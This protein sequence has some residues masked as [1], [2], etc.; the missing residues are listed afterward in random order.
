MGITICAL[1]GEG[2][3]DGVLTGVALNI[4]RYTF[5]LPQKVSDVF[6]GIS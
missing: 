1:L 6:G 4:N 5:L 3:A 2:L